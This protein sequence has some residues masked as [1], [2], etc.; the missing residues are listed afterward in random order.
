MFRGYPKL[1]VV[2]TTAAEAAVDAKPDKPTKSVSAAEAIKEKTS[3]KSAAAAAA[4]AAATSSDATATVVKDTSVKAVEISLSAMLK[5]GKDATENTRVDGTGH[6]CGMQRD[7]VVHITNTFR[8]HKRE[9]TVNYDDD[10]TREKK[11]DANLT[12]EQ[13]E[14]DAKKSVRGECMDTF[15][16][17]QYSISSLGKH[18]FASNIT[19]MLQ[20]VTSGAPG[21]LLNFDRTR[22]LMGK[23]YV[24]AYVLSDAFVA[25][26]EA[27]MNNSH[28]HK[29]T[30]EEKEEERLSLDR[31]SVV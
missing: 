11:K 16:V 25:H 4:A 29:P 28:N 26:A 22:T 13:Q 8:L 1:G 14:E 2:T 12:K 9:Y 24:R 7:N 5:I 15:V 23:P 10:E 30:L 31:K 19:K 3:G 6:L 17:G 27:Y 20:L 18:W 21:V